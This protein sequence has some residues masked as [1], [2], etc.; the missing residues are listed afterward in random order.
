MSRLLIL[1]RIAFAN[2]FSSMLNVFVGLVLLFGA[3]LLV[4]GGSVFTTLDDA[5]SKSIVGSI[6]GHV[7]VYGARSKDPLELYGRVDG[8]DSDLTPIDDF[9]GLKKKLL[10][11]PN[12]ERVVPMGAAT[13]MVTGGNNIDLT[14]EKFRDLVKKKD[15]LG[16]EAY[17]AK[18]NALIGQLRQIAKVLRED[19]D[20]AKELSTDRDEEGEA[21]LALTSSDEFWDSFESDPFGHLELLENKL[22]P[23]LVDGDMLFLRYLGTDLDAYQ[24]TFDRMRIVEGGKVP[25]GHRGILL[26]KFFMEEFMKLKNARRLDKIRDARAAGRKLSDSEDKDLQ[27]FV[28]ENVAQTRE[29]VLQLDE[30]G[31]AK[32]IADLQKFLGSQDKELPK[33][34]AIFFSVTDDNFDARYAWFYEHLAPMLSLYRVR[35]GD[36][37]TLRA[38]GK[39]GSIQSALV[40]VY[41][42]FELQGLEKSPLAGANALTDLVTFRTLYGFLTAE[43]KA[44]LDAMKAATGAKEVSRDNAEEALFGGD[45][46][47]V[48][49]VK[50]KAFEDKLPGSGEQ[51]AASRRLADTFPVS[52]VDEGVVMNA[53]IWLKDGSPLAVLQTQRDIEKA[54]QAE[55]PAV[56]PAHIAAAKALLEKNSLPMVLMATLKP[57]VELEEKRA[58]GEFAPSFDA[59]LALKDA[60]KTEKPRL[61]E[62][63]YKTIAALITG[64]SP[65]TWVVSWTS[66]AGFL[67]KFIDFFRL[68]LVAVVAAFAFFALI[69]VTIGMTIATLQRTATIGTLRAIGAQKGFVAM[70]VTVETV[71]LALVFGSVGALVGALAVRWLH[72]TGIPAFRDEL[73]FF[74]S[75]PVLRPELSAGGV[76]LSL[77]VVT[78][79]SVL[80]I[81]FPLVLATRVAPITAMQSQ[82]G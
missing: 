10:E 31:T 54:L 44:E 65:R 5:L 9:K 66:A 42:I 3:A 75:G 32:A 37:I 4:I 45:A 58:R 78:V 67:G 33:L 70:M 15:E 71:V 77:I 22:A 23:V 21:A 17:T 79:V 49:E 47:V 52:E 16:A 50:E 40:K 24:A 55:A 82:E 25:E 38:I 8:S 20:R 53:A 57:V 63:Q 73:Y 81:I 69:V 62:D 46:E 7:H 41:G 36:S 72:A 12:V 60:L 30:E 48:E 11:I 68:L 59:L 1:F 14:L 35:V 51:N 43:K 28:R 6:S 27:R 18:K 26:P 39:A 56:D 64:A 76:V 19:L 34:L 2:L 29:I 80:S 13:A 74:F 61:P